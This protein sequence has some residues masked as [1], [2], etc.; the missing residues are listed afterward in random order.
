M[1][2]W[3]HGC[4]R[5][6]LRAREPAAASPRL[7]RVNRRP[8]PQ[9][10]K[11]ISHEQDAPAHRLRHVAALAL[12]I[13]ST[14][15]PARPPS[16]SSTPRSATASPRRARTTARPPT[17][18]AP[19]P[20]AATARRTPGSTCR[21]APASGWSTAA[22]SPGLSEPTGAPGAMSSRM[23]RG[24][25]GGAGIGL[26]RPMSAR[27]SRR[28]RAPLARGPPRELHGRRARLALEGVRRDYPVSLHGVGLSLGS[29]GALDPRH[30]AGSARWSTASSRA[31]C[32]STCR[33]APRAGPI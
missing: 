4:R 23:R 10:T 1:V 15:R 3:T 13:A 31:W 9:P 30:L 29:D 33:G 7:T 16:P 25:A 22:I 8:R 20:R 17:P 27:S 14:G 12:P 2:T 26:R 28:A 32:P 11:E 5:G 21:P 18:P 6:S 19:A 24:R